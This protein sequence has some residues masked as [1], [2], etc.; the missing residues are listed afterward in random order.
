MYSETFRSFFRNDLK[1]FG[2]FLF[3]DIFLWLKMALWPNWPKFFRS[4]Q[5]ISVCDWR[6]PPKNR[7]K[8]SQGKCFWFFEQLSISSALHGCCSTCSNCL[9]L[10]PIK[11]MFFNEL[12][13]FVEDGL[14]SWVNPTLRQ[15]NSPVFFV[16]WLANLQHK[17]NWTFSEVSVVSSS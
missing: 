12:I 5:E 13:Q 6:I 11:S 1:I 9:I 17:I 4:F 2:H 8:H 10:H 3:W 16:S 15:H 14:S 7:L